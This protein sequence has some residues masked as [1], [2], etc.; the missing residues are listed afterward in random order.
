MEGV[1][2][3]DTP[4]C[5]M[6]LQ[7]VVC[8]CR[9]FRG[10]VICRVSTPTGGLFKREPCRSKQWNGE[11]VEWGVEGW[12]VQVKFQGGEEHGIETPWNVELHEE[13]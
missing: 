6:Q 9:Q 7:A 12:G 8:S 11:W 2:I 10:T 3:A 5:S 13:F 4:H 1:S